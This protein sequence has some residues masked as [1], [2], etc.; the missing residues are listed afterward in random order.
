MT[1]VVLLVQDLSQ[2]D[3]SSKNKQ[4][5]TEGTSILNNQYSDGNIFTLSNEKWPQEAVTSEKST[6]WNKLI[7]L[8]MNVLLG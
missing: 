7:H 8:C 5:S 6:I 3:S 4:A 2:E 1:I